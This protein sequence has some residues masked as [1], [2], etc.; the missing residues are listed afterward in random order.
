MTDRQ[1]QPREARAPVW[2]VDLEGQLVN[3]DH[4]NE[5]RTV[6]LDRLDP[7]L[8]EAYPLHI[9]GVV[10]TFDQTRARLLA[11]FESESEAGAALNRLRDALGAVR[12]I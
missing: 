4:H 5:L 2:I 9:W 3:L 7:D 1:T 10:G 8:Q 12:W 11:T 6:E